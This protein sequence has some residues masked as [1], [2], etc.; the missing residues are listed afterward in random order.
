[1]RTSTWIFA[2]LI[3]GGSLLFSALTA[4]A[5]DFRTGMEQLA[6]RIAKAAPEGKQLRVAVADFPDLQGVISEFGRYI[7]SRLTTRLADIKEKKSSS[8]SSGSGWSKSWRN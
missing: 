6:D 5:Q 7:A 8:S 4:S 3:V 1:M 2:I